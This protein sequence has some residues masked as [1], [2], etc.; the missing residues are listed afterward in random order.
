MDCTW[1]TQELK[2]EFEPKIELKYALFLQIPRC[3]AI[4]F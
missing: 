3:L 2:D 1:D 4:V